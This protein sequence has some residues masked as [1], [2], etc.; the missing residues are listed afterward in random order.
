[1]NKER[2]SE[3]DKVALSSQLKKTVTGFLGGFFV[4]VWAGSKFVVGVVVGVFVRFVCFCLRFFFF[5][6][7]VL[8]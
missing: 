7:F 2:T 3:Q 1:M 6:C 5:C 4:L 8:N